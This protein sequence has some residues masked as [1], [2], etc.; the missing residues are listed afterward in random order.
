MRVYSLVRLNDCVR[1]CA[2][3][4]VVYTGGLKTSTNLLHYHIIIAFI[5]EQQLVNGVALWL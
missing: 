2:E 4:C 5:E 3:L 1:V